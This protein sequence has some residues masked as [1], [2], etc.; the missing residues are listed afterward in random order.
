MG[1]AA[2]LVEQAVQETLTVLWC[3]GHSL[4]ED[5]NQRSAGAD[6]ERD[7]AQNLRCFP[8]WSISLNLAGARLHI[9]EATWSVKCTMNIRPLNQQYLSETEAVA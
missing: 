4:A 6:H 5:Q 8:G 2:D 3:S 7:P 1:K 9:A